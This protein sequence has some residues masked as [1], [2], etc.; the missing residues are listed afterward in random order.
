M[1]KIKVGHCFKETEDRL[2]A[3]YENLRQWY[4]LFW[5]LGAFSYVIGLILSMMDLA[6]V[7]AYIPLSGCMALAIAAIAA[8][9]PRFKA[10][11]VDITLDKVKEAEEKISELYIQNKLPYPRSANDELIVSNEAID[12]TLVGGSSSFDV[13]KMSWQEL[14]NFL[15]EIKPYLP[16]EAILEEIPSDD[17]TTDNIRHLKL[18]PIA[19][20]SYNPENE[21]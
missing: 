1:L 19:I 6:W 8:G 15:D 5:F 4:I 3:E 13:S 16:N 2:T 20:F 14:R 18:K 21:R 11:Y 10:L 7:N 12:I 9:V 17:S